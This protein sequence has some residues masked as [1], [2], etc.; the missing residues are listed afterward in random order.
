M[1]ILAEAVDYRSPKIRVSTQ[2]TQKSFSTIPYGIRLAWEHS[3]NRF[4]RSS[5]FSSTILFIVPPFAADAAHSLNNPNGRSGDVCQNVLP[6]LCAKPLGENSVS[7]TR[8]NQHAA[9]HRD[10]RQNR[11]GS[12]PK[13]TRRLQETEVNRRYG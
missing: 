6:C 8:V 2:H 11:Q 3:R 10:L 5:A 7:S 1:C 13:K 9:G 4:A 12:K